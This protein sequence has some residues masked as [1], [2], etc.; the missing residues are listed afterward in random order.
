[1]ADRNSYRIK[2]TTNLLEAL[3]SVQREGLL[4]QTDVRFLIQSIGIELALFTILFVGLFVR[5]YHL[6]HESIWID[7]GYSIIFAKLNFLQLIEETSK[8]VHTPFYYMIL[9]YWINIFGGS[10]FSIR[11]PSF[12]FGFLSIL[13]TYKVG[14]LIFDKQ[15]GLLSSLILGLSVFHIHYSQDARMYSLMTFLTVTSMY[16]FIRLVKERSFG[17]SI[18]YILSS[19]L[20]IYTHYFGLFIVIAQN[21]YFATLFLLS[22]ETLKIS[23]KRWVLLQ[24]TLTLLF[25]P[26]IAILIKQIMSVK[27]GFWIPEPTFETL[28]KSFKKYSGQYLFILFLVL[29]FIS[30]IKFEKIRGRINRKSLFKPIENYGNKNLLAFSKTYLL[31]VWLLTPIILPFIISKVLTPVYWDR[32]TIGAS[33][34]FYILIAKG[35]S[36]I[37]HRYVK[38][39]VIGV[40]V[41]GSA[42]NVWGY[43]TGTNKEQ[44]RSVADYIDANALPGDLVLFHADF[45]QFSFDYYST[46]TDLVKKP[47]PYSEVDEENIKNLRPAVRDHD[48]VWVI[49]AYTSDDNKERIRTTLNELHKQSYRGEFVSYA[50]AT[51]DYAYLE[52]YLFKKK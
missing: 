44:W 51:G 46:R 47:L 21:I 3:P 18:G 39:A 15:V 48:R 31:L 5:V 1:M 12:I 27:S 4:F 35:I 33:V 38:A 6:G 28:V 29:S 11:F 19:T 23:F 26:W 7:E 20:L 30:V 22:R 2:S 34:A 9:H 45:C 32:Y 14:S 24:V 10:E 17:V 37:S 8:D 43:H 41:I 36:N 49:L 25:A 13:M 42:V 16:F 40:V 50:Y 52:L